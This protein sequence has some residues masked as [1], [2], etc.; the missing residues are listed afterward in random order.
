[1]RYIVLDTETAPAYGR[2]TEKPEPQN[3]LV[4]DLG[5]AVIEGGSGEVVESYSIAVAETFADHRT[6]HSA[7]YADKLPLYYEGMYHG[8]R[9]TFATDQWRV[10]PFLDAM[11]LFREVCD[12]NGVT[13]VW[14]YNARF[15]MLALNSTCRMYSNGFR[16]HFLP[17]GVHWRDIWDYADCF[18]GT[19]RYVRW[20]FARGYV[21][22]LDNIQ[23]KE[24]CV[25]RYLTGDEQHVERH[26]ALSDA[27]EEAY[28]LNRARN[29]HTSKSLTMGQGWRKANKVYKEMKAK[30]LLEGAA[31]CSTLRC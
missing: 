18:T 8:E 30:G 19:Q 2:K 20:A 23:T 25:Y 4:Y 6:M 3:S 13:K 7:F 16:K 28:V 5:F 22:E 12:R 27:L 14:A 11:N 26:T 24:E 10:M 17:Y 9:N 31:D 21:S 29:K 15:D 1:M